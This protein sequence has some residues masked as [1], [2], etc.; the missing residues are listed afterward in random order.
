MLDVDGH[1][2]VVTHTAA[3][4]AGVCIS[5]KVPHWRARP[6]LWEGLGV[7]RDATAGVGV[8]VSFCGARRKA[9]AITFLN[10]MAAF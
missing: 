7:V 6:G 3:P 1:H 10:P 8:L 2:I 9:C 4:A 5:T